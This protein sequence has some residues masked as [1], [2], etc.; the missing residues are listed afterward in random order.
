MK[1]NIRKFFVFTTIFIILGLISSCQFNKSA[2]NE[3]KKETQ[4]TIEQSSKEKTAGLNFKIS[5]DQ[6]GQMADRKLQTDEDSVD[7]FYKRY[8]KYRLKGIY[9]EDTRNPL[10]TWSCYDELIDDPCINDLEPGEWTFILYGYFYRDDDQGV[11]IIPLI[12]DNTTV[13]LVAD[14]STDVELVL[15]P[16]SGGNA[17]ELN[18]LLSVTDYT[19]L[20]SSALLRI[21]EYD[22]YFNTSNPEY[23]SVTV[24]KT[25][26]I[27]HYPYEN[28]TD[29]FYN[30]YDFFVENLT[31]N[32]YWIK[33]YLQ[34]ANGKQHIFC[35]EQMIVIAGSYITKA[36][37][38]GRYKLNYEL[39]GGTIENG[40]F[41]GTDS[42]TPWGYYATGIPLKL[43]NPER[44]GYLFAGWFLDQECT[45]P[46]YSSNEGYI[47]N[48]LKTYAGEKTIYAKWDKAVKVN[49]YVY[50][51]KID[52]TQPF[53]TETIKKDEEIDLL[54]QDYLKD[55]ANG[56]GISIS[57]FSG[58]YEN[59]DCSGN[60][61]MEI[62]VDSDINFYCYT[63]DALDSFD[64]LSYESLLS[65]TGTMDSLKSILKNNTMGFL[66]DDT[67][68][69]T[70]K[71]LSNKNLTLNA[72]LW[73]KN[74]PQMY[75]EGHKTGDTTKYTI[76][77]QAN[78]ITEVNWTVSPS[79]SITKNDLN[80]YDF[81][82]YAA[83]ND[84]DN[85]T[86]ISC[87]Y[88]DV[89]KAKGSSEF[90]LWQDDS[91]N[92]E[93]IV[94]NLKDP[95]YY[96]VDGYYESE[97]TDGDNIEDKFTYHLP[98]TDVVSGNICNDTL[99]VPQSS[100][101]DGGT[102]Q[103]K[104]FAFDGWYDDSEFTQQSNNNIVL[105]NESDPLPSKTYYAKWNLYATPITITEKNNYNEDIQN[106]YYMARIPIKRIIPDFDTDDL[107][108]NSFYNVTFKGTPNVSFKNEPTLQNSFKMRISFYESNEDDQGNTTVDEYSCGSGYPETYPTHTITNLQENVPIERSFKVWINYPEGKPFV[109]NS[110]YYYVDILFAA[111]EHTLSIDQTLLDTSEVSSIIFSNWDIAFE[112]VERNLSE[113]KMLYETVDDSLYV[114]STD[115]LPYDVQNS[116]KVQSTNDYSKIDSVIDT[117]G[118]LYV[119]DYDSNGNFFVLKD[120]IPLFNQSSLETIGVTG[121][122][123]ISDLYYGLEANYLY[124]AGDNGNGATN[125]IRYDLDNGSISYGKFIYRFEKDSPYYEMTDFAVLRDSGVGYTGGRI[126]ASYVPK[127][128]NLTE[129]QG[130]DKRY[131]AAAD[132]VVNESNKIEFYPYLTTGYSQSNPKTGQTIEY[133]AYSIV[134]YADLF[135][136]TGNSFSPDLKINDMQIVESE[137]NNY[138]LYVLFSHFNFKKENIINGEGYEDPH[139]YL[140]NYGFIS[141]INVNN[142]YP[143]MSPYPS[144]T[145]SA[146]LAWDTS[147]GYG[148]NTNLFGLC[149]N[150]LE[151]SNIGDYFHYKAIGVDNETIGASFID[152]LINPQKFIAIEP[153]KLII[154]DDGLFVYDDGYG[155]SV[156]N[157]NRI[158]TVDLESLSYGFDSEAKY[159]T[160]NFSNNLTSDQL[161]AYYGD[162]YLK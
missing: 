18:F 73:Y 29:C 145:G 90:V 78:Q 92:K 48:K 103:M 153:K 106:T 34:D 150:A 116:Y 144:S 100:S 3:N 151:T 85:D 8:L 21:Y 141:R 54:S 143:E 159:V 108:K 82:L 50:N 162:T 41:E 28:I 87:S 9:N 79:Q 70:I 127:N 75:Y 15:K 134:S 69:Y 142:T 111:E 156:R 52:S 10:K 136:E 161:S 140:E 46:V 132:F 71:I 19:G 148:S 80:S 114:T 17:M 30:E 83:S 42:D 91:G 138:Y 76:T 23:K 128:L 63:G 66:E 53:I 102:Y 26:S 5:I 67:I 68:T 60:Q 72:G 84:I 25:K 123:N 51:S 59:A 7:F 146:G 94:L 16:N 107:L 152:Y 47:F 44:E 31:P 49:Y 109:S 4:K 125:F 95:S 126:F 96:S 11:A 139:Y 86:I 62:E 37:E 65:K 97:D 124:A 105:T 39:N 113:P 35:E 154:A 98:E 89:I 119:L 74:E 149:K 40:S 36:Y 104:G 131:I 88:S 115:Y 2:E 13:E 43:P 155:N 33:G 57:R 158:V 160:T 45:K 27:P 55:Y 61:I 101:G 118:H 56:K 121:K 77:V 22:D 14:E 81:L 12:S 58:W 117:D 147:F 20:Y 133:D 129:L 122:I 99:V 157:V 38:I 135:G 110:S 137:D 120:G 24:D 112:F 130:F 1:I 32:R 6:S 93:S 64:N